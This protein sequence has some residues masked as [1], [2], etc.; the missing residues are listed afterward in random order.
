[1]RIFLGGCCKDCSNRYDV[2][3]ILRKDL[4]RFLI[5]SGARDW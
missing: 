3:Y 4:F 2:E 5:V 1:M